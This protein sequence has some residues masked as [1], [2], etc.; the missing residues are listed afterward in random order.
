VGAECPKHDLTPAHNTH[1]INPL[2]LLPPPP[3]AVY[4]PAVLRGCRVPQLG[5]KLPPHSPYLLYLI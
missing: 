5:P 3:A 4:V 1:L 2:P